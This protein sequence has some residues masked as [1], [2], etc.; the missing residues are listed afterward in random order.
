MENLTEIEIPK[1][2]QFIIL[3]HH[4]NEFVVMKSSTTFQK[5]KEYITEKHK[6]L[7]DDK[8]A[9]T[10][11]TGARKFYHAN[12]EDEFYFKRSPRSKTPSRTTPEEKKFLARRKRIE[13]WLADRHRFINLTALEKSISAPKGLIQKFVKYDTRIADKWIDPIYSVLKEFNSFKL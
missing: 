2:N 8:K 13:Q 7:S 1:E 5:V 3:W 10:V 4:S 6:T 11:L 9:V 12:A